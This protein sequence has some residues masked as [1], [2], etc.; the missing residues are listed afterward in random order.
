MIQNMVAQ[1]MIIFIIFIMQVK[2]TVTLNKL[3]DE[4]NP[5]GDEI[6]FFSSDGSRSYKKI[7]E[8]N[9]KKNNVSN[10]LEHSNEIDTPDGEE[11][12]GVND[13]DMRD[14]KQEG[15]EDIRGVSKQRQKY[16][17]SYSEEAEQLAIDCA[18]A[19]RMQSQIGD[20]T[21]W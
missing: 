10:E 6:L 2:L 3:S 18:D 16:F 5:L 8:L 7:L 14:S 1:F 12:D 9:R 13:D 21:V 19:L 20:V 4:P 11:N 17:V 15:I